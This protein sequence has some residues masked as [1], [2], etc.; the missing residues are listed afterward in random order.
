MRWLALV[1]LIGCSDV[2]T[3][4][5]TQCP[6]PDPGT[7]TYENFGQQFMTDYCIVCHDEALTSSQRNGAPIYHDFETLEKVLRTPDHID[8]EAGFGPEAEN[9]FMPPD[10]CPSEP[11]GSIDTDCRKPT[12]D[13]RRMLAE[14]LACEKNR[15]HTF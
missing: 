13:E 6:D 5:E 3:P 15:P 10:R 11:G 9:T 14:W 4:T 8:R 1:W 12:D 7:L 2:P